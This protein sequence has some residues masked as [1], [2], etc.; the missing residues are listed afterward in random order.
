MK[1]VAVG[2]RA[3]SVVNS[4][5]DVMALTI[6][7]LSIAYAAFAL[8][9]SNQIYHIADKSYYAVYKPTVKNEGRTF[10]ELQAINPE[11]IAW[12][13][14]FGTNIDYPVPQGEYNMKY[15]NTNVEGQYSFSGSIFLDSSNSKDFSNFNSILHGH[16]MEK[17]AMF[18]DVGEFSE[19]E[20]FDTHLYGNLYYDETDH[21][22][23]FFAFVRTTAYDQ[24]VFRANL[25]DNEQRQEYLDYLLANA[26]YK[27]DIGVTTGDRIILLITCSAA[28]THGRDVLA[29]RITDRVFDDSFYGAAPDLLHSV[30]SQRGLFPMLTTE[31][32]DI[33][34]A[35]AMAIVIV[36]VIVI[37]PITVIVITH[38]RNKEERY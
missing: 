8:W 2:R 32:R 15:I 34:I 31:F 20:I 14:V 1:A 25:Q 35:M 4:I 7:I 13:N 3:I 38:R 33:A 17:N 6:I 26:M 9:D 12:V 21:G 10:K 22:I 27:R 19:K 36:A 11:V 16:H 29:G 23:E 28:A 5:V 24:M 18:G 37:A 30:D